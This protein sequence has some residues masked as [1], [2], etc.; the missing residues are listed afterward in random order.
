MG[1]Q[2]FGSIIKTVSATGTPEALGSGG[3]R[4]HSVTFLGLKA[5]RTNNAG[6]VWISPNSGNDT[7]AVPLDPGDEVTFTSSAEDNYFTDAQFFI[8]VETAGDGCVAIYDK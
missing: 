7:A 2:Q 6:K 8:D 3:V 1:Q 4:A 5:A